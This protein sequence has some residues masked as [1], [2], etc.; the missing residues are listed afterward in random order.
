[1]R[2]RRLVLPPVGSAMLVALLPLVRVPCQEAKAP[3]AEAS[4]EKFTAWPRA[5]KEVEDDVA[6][7]CQELRHTTQP[8]VFEKLEARLAEKGTAI[9]P[10]LLDRLSDNEPNINPS[11]QRVLNQIVDA[12]Y[13]TPLAARAKEKKLAVRTYVITR[14]T[15]FGLPESIPVFE[16][17]RK[18]KDLAFQA[19]LGLASAG[20]LD[21]LD[22]I[23]AK[24]REDWAGLGAR[25]SAALS[26]ARGINGAASVLSK[27]QTGDERTI[28]TGLRLLRSLAPKELTGPIVP[29]L[30]HE[31][32]G[33]KKEAINTLRV[34]VDGAEP[35]EEL[36]AFQAIE[37]AN[38]W[39][40]RLS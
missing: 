4:A 33:V 12:R 21:G 15:D 16:A 8:A 37:M 6:K 32:Q 31:F 24:A 10:L 29:F 39:K 35:L 26:H 3:A 14:L 13:A 20:K 38:E 5:T 19:A 2:N 1:M 22:D 7:I 34:I 18:D 27:I 36:S 30:D 25:I 28:V 9:A 17:A 11:L 40:K 23:F